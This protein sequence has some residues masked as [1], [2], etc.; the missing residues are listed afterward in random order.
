MC[1]RKTLVMTGAENGSLWFLRLFKMVKLSSK[2]QKILA[3]PKRFTS[4]L[5]YGPIFGHIKLVVP[6]I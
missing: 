2:L 1:I 4:G 3:F 6:A 5:C